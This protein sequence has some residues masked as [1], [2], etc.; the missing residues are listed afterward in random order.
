METYSIED[1]F[2]RGMAHLGLG[3]RDAARTWLEKASQGDGDESAMARAQLASLGD[4]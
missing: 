4:T 1:P 3:D 2:A